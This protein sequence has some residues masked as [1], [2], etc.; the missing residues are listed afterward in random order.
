MDNSLQDTTS[1]NFFRPQFVANNY[2]SL[3]R[4]ENKKGLAQNSV[5]RTP[6]KSKSNFFL[7]N[8]VCRSLTDIHKHKD[9]EHSFSKKQQENKRTETQSRQS[10]VE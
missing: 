10:L 9:K 2:L 1:S 4:G 7:Q 8:R 3:S 5:Q 6:T